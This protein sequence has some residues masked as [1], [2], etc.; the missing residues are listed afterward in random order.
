[1]PTQE[2]HETVP[3]HATIVVS[4]AHAGDPPRR[5]EVLE[6]LG[7]AEHPHYLVRWEDGRETLF[8]PSANATIVLPIPRALAKTLT[9][10]GA[11]FELLPHRHTETARAEARAVGSTPEQIA[12]TVVIRTASGYVRV[13]VPASE[14]VDLRKLRE[15]LG[16]DGHTRL[17]TEAELA[18]AYPEFELGAVPPMGGPAGDA[19]V[20]DKTLAGH[21]QVVFEAGTHDESIRMETKDLL[22]LADA[23]VGDVS[24]M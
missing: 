9:E 8:Y 20:V 22:R 15:L 13:V 21:D 1:M 23:R 4:G 10:H 2:T 7:T 24:Q 16:G 3:R 14:R 17:A 6:T 18:A 19:V 5:G 12:K 11:P